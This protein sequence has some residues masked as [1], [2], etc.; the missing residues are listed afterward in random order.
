MAA[1]LTLVAAG[2]LVWV[3]L[4]G[5]VQPHD[6]YEE[7][8][9]LAK[10]VAQFPFDD[11]S[12]ASSITDVVGAGT[13]TATNG[14]A[15]LGEE[16]PFQGAHSGSFGGLA[17]AT[18]PSYP[19]TGATEFTAEAWVDFGG[20]PPYGQPVFAFGSGSTSYLALTPSSAASKHPLTFE[21]QSGGASAV[22]ATTSKLPS[23]TWEY[24]AVTESGG[25]LKLYLNGAKVAETTGVSLSPASLESPTGNYLGRS[26]VSGSARFQG[27]L[28][29][30]AFYKAALSAKQVTEHYDVGESPVET[31]PPAIPG[32]PVEGVTVTASPGS[33]TG[34]TPF[35]FEYAWER[36]GPSSCEP[37]EKGASKAGYVPVSADVASKLRVQVTAKNAADETPGVTATSAQSPTVEGK[38]ANLESPAVTGTPQVGQLLAVSEGKWRSFPEA[39]FGFQWENCVKK[40]CA[41]IS[42]A[43]GRHY[44]VQQSDLGKTVRATVTGKNAR[45]E[46]AAATTTTATV[47]AGPPLNL[48][49]PTVSGP[50]EDGGTLTVHKGTWAGSEPITYTDQWYRC[51]GAV[52]EC[53]PIGGATA[54]TLTLGVGDIGHTFLAGVTAKNSAGSTGATSTATAVVHAAAPRNTVAPS[55]SGTTQDEHTLS[56]NRGEWSGTPTITYSYQWERCATTCEEIAGATGATYGLGHEDAGKTIKVR[57]SATNAGGTSDATSAATAAVAASPPANV[58]LPSISGAAEDGHALTAEDGSWSGTPPFSFSH[59]W[60]RCSEAGT[61][62]AAIEAATGSTYSSSSADIGHTIRVSVT[63]TNAAGNGS[64][65]SSPTAVVTA[66]PPANVEAPTVTGTAED[67]STLSTGNGTWSGTGPISYSYRWERCLGTDCSAISGATAASYTLVAEDVGHTIRS[68]VTATNTVDSASSA[69]AATGEVSPRPPANVEAPTISGTARQGQLLTASNGTWSGTEPISYTYEWESCDALGEGCL[70]IPGAGEATYTPSAGDVGST[71]R[72]L[73]TAHNAGGEAAAS[74][75]PTSAVAAEGGTGGPPVNVEPPTISGEP[76]V[77]NVLDV[78]NGTWEGAEPI[79]YSYQWQRCSVPSVGPIVGP[80]ELSISEGVATDAGGNVWIANT[81][82]GQLVEVDPEGHYLRTA[83]SEGTEP[84][85]LD[86]PEAVAIAPGGNVWVASFSGKTITEFSPEGAYITRIDTGEGTLPYALDVDASG[87]VWLA[88]PVKNQVTEYSESG[89]VIQ[90]WGTAGSEPGQ[91][92]LRFPF[93]I[94]VRGGHVWLTDSENNRIEEFTEAGVF[95]TAF[96]ETGTGPGQFE[97]PGDI[98]ID[99]HGNLWVVDRGNNRVQEFT[100]S[101]EFIRAA[102][103]EGFGPG[104]LFDPYALALGPDGELWV[105]DATSRVK[106]LQA[107][108]EMPRTECEAIPGATE[109]SYT[110]T[111]TDVGSELQAV[112]TASNED[113]EASATAATGTTVTPGSEEPPTLVEAPTISETPVSGE[114][115]GVSNGSW[116]GSAPIRFSYAW[117]LCDASGESCTPIEGAESATYT[118]THAQIGSTLRATVTARNGAGEASSTTEASEPILAPP[119]NVE[120][121]TVSG[122][123]EDEQTLTASTGAWEGTPPLTYSYR[124]QRCDAA[125][126]AC[127]DIPGATGASYE[128]AHGDVSRTLRALVTARSGRATAT[129]ASVASSTIRPSPPV[130][131]VRPVIT[132]KN[133]PGQRLSGTTGTWRGTPPLEFAY[134]WTRCGLEGEECE[135]IP[136]ATGPEHELGS[137]E[138]GDVFRLAVTATNEAASAQA[139]ASFGGTPPLDST[140]PVILGVAEVRHHLTVLN[141][142]WAGTL[143]LEY[144]YQWQRCNTSAEE[145]VDISQATGTEYTPVDADAGHTLRVVVTATSLEGTSTAVSSA[146]P[147]ITSVLESVAA[148]RVV[149][150]PE[151]GSELTVEGATWS[152]PTPSAVTYQWQRCS[153]HAPAEEATLEGVV[154]PECVPIEGAQSATYTIISADADSTL[155]AVLTA[156]AGEEAASATSAET[157]IVGETKPVNT[158]APAILGTPNEGATVSADPGEWSGFGVAYSYQWELCNEQ[159]EACKPVAGETGA[160]FDVPFSRRH[161]TM[162]GKTIRVVVGAAN[163]VGSSAV[164]SAPSA[165]IRQPATIADRTPP[166]LSG[167][168]QVGSAMTA[169]QGAWSGAGAIGYAYQW[170]ECDGPGTPCTSIPGATSST[171]T[172]EAAQTGKSLVVSVTATD[173]NSASTATST[174]SQPVAGA[175]E[176]ASATPP[177]ISGTPEEGHA[178]SAGPGSW[179]SGTS[180]TYAYQWLACDGTGSGCAP[181]AGA[182]SGTFSPDRAVL[183]QTLR[184][185]VTATNSAGASTATSPASAAVTSM[186]ANVSPPTIALTGTQQPTYSADPGIWVGASPISYSYQWQRCDA[187]GSSCEDIAG[188]EAATYTLGSQDAGG[189]TLRVLAQAHNAL[190]SAQLPSAVVAPAIPGAGVWMSGRPAPGASLSAESSALAHG[191]SGASFQ[192]RR[193]NLEGASCADIAGATGRSYSLTGADLGSSV[194]VVVTAE[195]AGPASS[196]PVPIAAPQ[197]PPSP[198]EIG[199]NSASLSPGVTLTAP[200]L[201]THGSEPVSE[202]FTWERCDATGEACAPIEGETGRSYLLQAADIGSTLRVVENHANSFGEHVDTSLATAVVAH[203]GPAVIASP[204]ISAQGGFEPGMVASVSS[205]SWAGDAP[206]AFSYQWQLCN[207][208]GSECEAVAGA[209]DPSYQLEPGTTG[210]S[211]R[212]VVSASNAQGTGS[213]IVGGGAGFVIASPSGSPASISPPTVSGPAVVGATLTAGPGVWANGPTGTTYAYQWLRCVQGSPGLGEPPGPFAEGRLCEPIEGATEQTYVLKGADV[214]Q[215]IAVEVSATNSLSLTGTALSAQTTEVEP[216]PPGVLAGHAPSISHEAVVGETLSVSE[217]EWNSFGEES[218]QWLRCDEHGASCEAISGATGTGLLLTPSFVGATLRVRVGLL[219]PGGEGSFTTG[220]TAPVLEPGALSAEAGP[221]ITG[222]ATVGATLTA[223]TGAWAGTRPVSYAWQWQRC[224]EGGT[225]CAPIPGATGSRYTPVE[226]DAGSVLAVTVTAT[227]AAGSSSVSS[228]PSAT[229][230]AAGAPTSVTAPSL[231]VLLPPTYG[232]A[233]LVQSGTWTGGPVVVDEW[234]RCDPANI[235]PETK[236]PRCTTIEGA[237]GPLYTPAAADVG[238]ELRVKEVVTN[239]AGSASSTTAMSEAVKPVEVSDHGGSYSGKLVAGQAIHAEST[240]TSVPTLPEHAT[241]QFVRKSAGGGETPL[242]SGTDPSYTLTNAD[243]GSEIVITIKAELTALGS[244]TQIYASTNTVTTSK[245]EGVLTAR[246]LPTISGAFAAG[247]QLTAGNGRWAAGHH[248]V[249]YSYQWLHCDDAGR[250]C[251]PIPEATEETYNLPEGDIGARDRLEVTADDGLDQ[252]TEVSE[253][254]PLIEAPTG[255]TNEALPTITGTPAEGVALHATTGGWSSSEPIEYSYQ[256]QVCADTETPCGVDRRRRRAG[257]HP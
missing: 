129:A 55:I 85:Q 12:G 199:A 236:Q 77:G 82:K 211:L 137:E 69:S 88:E 119:V 62:C 149:G 248:T 156:H 231:P 253:P 28:S 235:D 212:V 247:S 148:P 254:T 121:P 152:G 72:A 150:T 154:E 118:P 200:A 172:P 217:G 169:D 100:S 187:T 124:W 73:V 66:A 43:T 233:M 192:W 138:G 79:T 74:S 51:N 91:F 109:S 93:G 117:Q 243:I 14:G 240:V 26:P 142:T 223:S 222:T 105:T 61:E 46:T 63:A 191:S 18:L 189:G 19:L 81:Y 47:V 27:L 147:V 157:R 194:L 218:Y 52:T 42:E 50:A 31:A 39:E 241:Y 17:S 53:N 67:G 204:T 68:V 131:V 165:P 59:Q 239:H 7:A 25:A 9:A 244:G 23:S 134:E 65:T 111:T 114:P 198:I 219:G 98:A 155:R 30:V 220:A 24:I 227:N 89:E 234:Q 116:T 48:E 158:G 34:L 179:L 213:A 216:P 161:E 232:Q 166:T 246:G 2:A 54:E 185:V 202:T 94:A 162:L 57:V 35:K 153:T 175:A 38:P 203:A 215:T 224:G 209:T 252:G 113:G 145:C 140:P 11:H 86:E 101:G 44:R 256:W 104:Q 20:A 182:T 171:F 249:T 120:R 139:L 70:P 196:A 186:L 206:I 110:P 106:R 22:V 184:V 160:A 112:V 5:G 103:S 208:G 183:G 125:G 201:D 123:A 29:N 178:V 115:V 102:G 16:G 226:A 71:L 80:D 255:P 6:E 250:N 143:D 214:G 177:T 15:V 108:G 56:A 168:A 75:E 90:Q 193:C 84:G 128:I 251:E 225:G 221:E 207:E 41:T 21:I 205:G 60:Q 126:E 176:P 76:R 238:F 195:G 10:P 45:G 135:P 64:A 159:G 136:G 122:V 197:A 242:Q 181:I 37:I 83:G 188:A 141:G 257:L 127:A 33:W 49:A 97:H 170:Q 132:G 229:V 8:V 174:E 4:A 13:Y 92:G 164:V 99:S 163:E 180:V 3:A 210:R 230:T 144:S 130:D 78:S 96:G 167:V 133:E 151:I 58:H 87:H 95:E 245:V 107:N 173:E 36:C 40:V 32:T 237:T 1:A 146:T 228:T 190:R